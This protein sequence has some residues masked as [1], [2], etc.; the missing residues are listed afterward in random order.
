M[1][2]LVFIGLRL[3]PIKNLVINISIP[4]IK[5]LTENFKSYLVSPALRLKDIA[6][7]Q[8]NLEWKTGT[9]KGDAKLQLFLL[10]RKVN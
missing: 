5:K 10:I 7:K 4:T 1:L 3:I 6:G 9:V 8:L 2:K